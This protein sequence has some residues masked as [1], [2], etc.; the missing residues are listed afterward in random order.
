LINQDN[1][2][3][4]VIVSLIPLMIMPYSIV[5]VG[6]AIIVAATLTI[7]WENRR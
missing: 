2:K 7:L 4:I 5:M 6:V 3:R 1:R